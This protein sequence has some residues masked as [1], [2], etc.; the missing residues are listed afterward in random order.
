M[1]RTCELNESGNLLRIF[2]NDK[3]SPV[4]VVMVDNCRQV[5]FEDM[6]IGVYSVY[7]DGKKL[8][9]FCALKEAQAYILELKKTYESESISK[10]ETEKEKTT[11]RFSELSD[12]G[13]ALIG[14]DDIKCRI[15]IQPGFQE[16]FNVYVENKY[17]VK[18]KIAS[19][20]ALQM[21]RDYLLEC[22]TNLDSQKQK[23]QNCIS[24]CEVIRKG[25]ENLTE[26]IMAEL[27]KSLT[28]PC[29]N[30]D[31]KPAPKPKPMP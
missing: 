16:G 10:M 25:F 5:R 29:H 6:W 19:F 31:K 24:I 18:Q 1:S 9:S 8:A 7:Q 30:G 23:E 22:K 17:N 4:S 28:L 21:A 15:T 13:L 2:D 27:K 20:Y 3:L 14:Y 11:I 12:D 26:T